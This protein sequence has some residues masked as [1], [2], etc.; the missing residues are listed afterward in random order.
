MAPALDLEDLGVARL[1]LLGRPVVSTELTASNTTATLA[2]AMLRP[3]TY[4]ARM[5]NACAK[6]TIA[7]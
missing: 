7:N 1:D 3:G 4:F 5:G 2:R 6:F